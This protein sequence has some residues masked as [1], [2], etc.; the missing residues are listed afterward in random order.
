[1]AQILRNK[2]DTEK[3]LILEGG[4]DEAILPGSES[5]LSKGKFCDE[6]GKAQ[7][8]ATVGNYSCHVSYIDRRDRM[9]PK[10]SVS[11]KIW[12]WTKNNTFFTRWVQI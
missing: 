11:W 12:R 5:E 3:E 6:Y 10:S 9:T 7:K 8:P 2:N 4:F 1:M